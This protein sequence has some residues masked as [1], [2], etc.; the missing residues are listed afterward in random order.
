[1]QTFQYLSSIFFF[2]RFHRMRKTVCFKRF[3]R[4]LEG[5]LGTTAQRCCETGWC[6]SWQQNMSPFRYS[7]ILVILL[8][9]SWIHHLH[10]MNMKLFK[11]T[12]K[13]IKFLLKGAY[14]SFQRQ[15]VIAGKMAIEN[16]SFQTWLYNVLCDDTM[17][18]EV[19]FPAIRFVF[20]SIQKL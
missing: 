15:A 13:C 4:R 10:S 3:W 8:K 12:V 16:I 2:I 18:D 11:C 5:F 9:N 19:F 6:G 14:V 1:M 7:N 17:A 20:V